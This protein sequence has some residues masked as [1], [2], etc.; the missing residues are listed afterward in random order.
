MYQAC[1][2]LNHTLDFKRLVLSANINMLAFL[3]N[4]ITP[5]FYTLGNGNH[6]PILRIQSHDLRYCN[7]H[8]FILAFLTSI[9]FLYFL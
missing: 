6:I 3:L 5:I 7:F 9:Y 1:Y 8:L 2:L 4:G